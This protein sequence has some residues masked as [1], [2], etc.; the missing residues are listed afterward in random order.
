MKNAMLKTLIAGIMIIAFAGI[1]IVYAAD[2]MLDTTVSDTVKRLDKNGNEYVRVIIDEAKELNGVSYTASTAV[3][4]FGPLVQ[5]AKN[6]KKGDA[7]KV[8][9]SSSEYQGRTS[10]TAVAFVK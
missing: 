7:L 9:A 2:Q 5:E 4:F 10:Y 1:G 8:I 6:L 3:M